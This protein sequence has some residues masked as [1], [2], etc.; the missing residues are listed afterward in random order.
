M[1]VSGTVS[2]HPKLTMSRHPGAITW[3]IPAAAGPSR[4]WGPADRIP[5]QISSA[6]SVVVISRH[7]AQCPPI[8]SSSM[9]R[10]PLPVAWKMMGAYPASSKRAAHFSTQAVVFPN[11]ETQIMG[12]SFPSGI[13]SYC[14]IPQTA[15]AALDMIILEK[16]F[17]PQIST[18]DG[19]S[20]MSL[21]P[22]YSLVSPDASVVIHTLGNPNGRPCMAV[23][24]MD[25]PPPP[26]IPITPWMEC[27]A[28]NPTAILR[29]PR[30]M[31]FMAQPRSP[32]F[33]SSSRGTPPARATS[34]AAIRTGNEPTGSNIPTSMAIMSAPLLSSSRYR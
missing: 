1:Y 12:L 14:I 9:E 33:L 13:K 24:A 3:G 11:I 22:T 23:A 26:P 31:I 20:T 19:N 27:S 34:C 25:V 4:R 10:P 18:M 8:I 5:W 16:R 28:S 17:S 2:R 15:P 6:H 7:A 32:F 30:H 29:A 21:V